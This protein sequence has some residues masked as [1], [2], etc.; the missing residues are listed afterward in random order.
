MANYHN[1]SDELQKRILR[2]NKNVISKDTAVRRNMQKDRANLHRGAFVRDIE[3]ILH[4]PYYNRCADKTQVFSFYKNDDIT[5]RALHVQIVSRIA[6]NIGRLLNLDLD[7]IEAIALGHDIGHT[8]FGHTGEFILDELLFSDTGLHF[9]HNL[10]S[11]RVLDKLFCYNLSLQTLDGI[12]S[13]NGEFELAKYKPQPISTFKEFDDKCA[14][15]A[16]DKE[17]AAS[18]IPST[19][20][21]CVVRISDIIA[22]LGKDRQD[23]MKTHLI[24]SDNFFDDSVIGSFNAAII[25]NLTVNIVEKSYGKDYLEMD[26]EYFLALQSAKKDNYTY[27]YRADSVGKSV[28]EAVGPMFEKIYKKLCADLAANKKD[29]VVFRHHIDYLKSANRFNKDYSYEETTDLHI[30][31][32]DFIASMTDDYFTDLYEYLFP[33]EKTIKYVSYFDE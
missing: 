6:R 33:G 23:A 26:E 4:C 11:V 29:S 25:N 21:G 31:A 1:L 24:E 8:P 18:V 32:A 20:E 28:K 5:R 27:I 19:L 7:L 17:A 9:Y 30:I 2:E 15:C 12:L 16:K 14:L 22:Y 10:Q 3:K 13:H